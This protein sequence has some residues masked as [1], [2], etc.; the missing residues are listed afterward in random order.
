MKLKNSFFILSF[1]IISSFE[2]EYQIQNK[3]RKRSIFRDKFNPWTFPIKYHIENHVDSKNVEKALEIISK[4]TCITFNKSLTPISNE[5]GIQFKWSKNSCSS[6]VGSVY[7]NKPNTILLADGC[8]KEV[9]L[10]IHEICHSLGLIH[11]QSRSDRDNY[12]SIQWDKI[13]SE[14]KNS[15]NLTNHSAYLTYLTSYDYGSIMHYHP[16][17]F[18][19]DKSSRT[20]I[21]KKYEEYL[22][23][24]GQY[25]YLSFN[26]IK[27][28]NLCHC[29]K[30]KWVK[31]NS[32][33]KNKTYKGINCSR[34]G[35]PDFRNCSRCI[36]P[37][38]F[39]GRDCNAVNSNPSGC[40]SSMIIVANRTLIKGS[41]IKRCIN[42][43]V[44]F[45]NKRLNITIES[46]HA[47]KAKICLQGISVEVKYRKDKG[48]T[49]LLFC[50]EHKNKTIITE[51]HDALIFYYGREEKNFMNIIVNMIDKN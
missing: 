26:D 32:G 47:S 37:S 8:Q 46:L 38:G 48:A 20:M 9:G 30:C 21:P 24:M 2:K 42:Y 49:G 11:E 18:S 1:L 50:G 36:C 39:V 51:T 45:E 15:Y 43:V 44:T 29:N 35:Y 12:I 7:I 27:K 23:M 31:I 34:N 16:T 40:N 33:R 6:D 19:M 14:A 17:D 4:E 41:G 22:D 10:I 25:S 13:K 28:L 5:R 3:I